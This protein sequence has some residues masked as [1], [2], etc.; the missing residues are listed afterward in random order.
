IATAISTN[1]C[2]IWRRPILEARR[3]RL[4]AIAFPPNVESWSHIETTSKADLDESD[5]LTLSGKFGCSLALSG[6]SNKDI[7]LLQAGPGLR[8]GGPGGQ[9]REGRATIRAHLR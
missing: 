7:R 3:E 4:S 9:E 1:S 2:V 5:Q 6:S 8:P